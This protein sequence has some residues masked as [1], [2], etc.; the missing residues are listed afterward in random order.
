LGYQTRSSPD[1]VCPAFQFA[2]ATDHASTPAV[3]SGN[4][5]PEFR[6]RAI[7]EASHPFALTAGDEYASPDFV[8]SSWLFLELRRFGG[9]PVLLA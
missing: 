4:R 6:P 2:I 3:C 7:K 1:A 5:L 9:A 8:D